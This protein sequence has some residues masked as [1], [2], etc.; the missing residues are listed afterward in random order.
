MLR[1]HARL[2]GR[3]GVHYGHGERGPGIW[4]GSRAMRGV[5]E[6]GRARD[7]GQHQANLEAFTGAIRTGNCRRSH[8]SERLGSSLRIVEL[9]LVGLDDDHSADD[10]RR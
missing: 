10:Q 3:L 4:G 7:S 9:E 5:T 2:G 6:G 1:G 8:G